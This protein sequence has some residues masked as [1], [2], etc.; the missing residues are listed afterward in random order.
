MITACELKR[1]ILAIASATLVRAPTQK[2]VAAR[3]SRSRLRVN[4][5][6]SP[7]WIRALKA[8][9]MILLVTWPQV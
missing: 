1:P 6:S 4:S 2:F 8:V 9:D 3:T 5:S 7:P